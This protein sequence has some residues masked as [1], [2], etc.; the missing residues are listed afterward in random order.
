[1]TKSR[2]AS[3][4]ARLIGDDAVIAVNSS[5][6]L[7]CPDAVLAA[8]GERFERE[9]HPRNLTSIHPIAAGD[10]FGTKGVDHIAR[11]GLL[12]RIIGGSYP[13]GPTKAEPPLIWQMIVN[14][15]VQ[16]YNVPSGIVFDILREA[17]AKRPGVLT[18]VGMETFVDP[19]IEACAMN[20]AARQAPIVRRE[21][22]DGD[23]WLYFPSITPDVAIIRATTADENGNL[24]FEHEGAYLGAVE[25]ALAARNNGGVVIAQVK[26]IAKSGSLRPHDVQV[27]GILVDVI[28]ETPDQLQTTATQYDPAISGELIRP[29]STF[30]L[31][32]FNVSKVIARRVARELKKGWAV[33]IGFGISA[34]VPRIFAEEGQHG[35]VTWMIE[36][37]AVGG[38][39][40]LDFK[41]GCSANAEAFVTSPHQ[42]SYFQAGG[43]D[44]S[45]LSFLEVDR[46]G[47]VNVSRLSSVPHR[48][49][50]AGGFVDITARARKIVF[51]GNF[52]AGAK[53]SIADGRLRIDQEGKIAKFVDKVDQVSFSGDRARAQKQDVTYV[54]ERC[55]IKL[56]G[57]GLMVTE[58]APGIDVERDVLAQSHAQLAV[59]DTLKT[60]DE[61][62]FSPEP[63]GLDL[64]SA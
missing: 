59:S 19:D 48:T 9:G 31:P 64:E 15:E 32:E 46:R 41:F 27:A 25:M 7:C 6:G 5:S 3:E 1:M 30:T 55:V 14:N 35:A 37:G 44:A 11:K 18:K 49:A 28:V 52:N 21:K 23:E 61:A 58:I 12:S 51:S 50:G 39:P 33:N 36:Q 57:N 47:S 45:L 56:N 29:M 43:F 63:I 53:M 2:T 38:I 26:R 42:F 54:T 34:N 22:F 60:M 10:M 8:I 20:D 16:A 17:A 40:L 13:S 24:T 62:L 4:A